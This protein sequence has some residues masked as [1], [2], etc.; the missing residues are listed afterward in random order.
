MSTKNAS[1]V[2]LTTDLV[3]SVKALKL[4]DGTEYVV[5]RLGRKQSGWEARAMNV[6]DA[7]I[8]LAHEINFK[9]PTLAPLPT[10]KIPLFETCACGAHG[11]EHYPSCTVP[12]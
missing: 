5:A 4:A 3:V 7:L 2:V 6:A 1:R 9:Q 10:A 12:K 8:G 11:D